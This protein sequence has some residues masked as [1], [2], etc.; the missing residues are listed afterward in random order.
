FCLTNEQQ[1]LHELPH[2]ERLSFRFEKESLQQQVAYLL[3]HKAAALE[4][5]V[6]VAEAYK[7]KHPRV[8]TVNKILEYASLAK[9]DNLRQ[10]PAGSQDFFMWPPARL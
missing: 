1:F 2:E 4:M 5:G 7:T 6:E 3:D 8:E 9:L 10:R